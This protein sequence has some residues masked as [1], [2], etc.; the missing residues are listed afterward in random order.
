VTSDPVARYLSQ[1]SARHER[2]L[3]LRPMSSG[4]V[5]D[6]GLRVY[7]ALG[8]TFLRIT[9]VPALFCLAGFAFLVLY[10]LPGL[11]TTAQP[12]DIMVQIAEASVALAMA[13][14]I[15]GPLFLLGFSYS[16]AVITH[17][18]ADY[19]VGN[20]LDPAQAERQARGQLPKLFFVSMREL[21]LSVSGLGVA[22]ALM[23]G[24]ALLS[25]MTPETSALAGL[26]AFVGILGLFGGVLVFLYVASRHA[27]AAPAA[28]L[29]DLSGR[30]AA[31]RSKELFRAVPYHGSGTGAIWT[32][33]FL[34]FFVGLLLVGGMFLSAQMLGMFG[35]LEGISQ[36]LPFGDT[37]LTALS[38]LPWYVVIWTLLPV[39]AATVVLV[40][41][42]RRVRLEGYDIEALASEIGRH[43]RASRF[44]L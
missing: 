13:L 43:G 17:L 3:Q 22:I 24:G 27:L 9:A 32:L 20:P 33:Y 36:A 37:I 41:Y 1:R 12:M 23:M 19:V 42:E 15:G 26:V 34:L 2:K 8:W 7:Q 5:I 14:F 18:V 31:A 28:V 29:E 38:L 4:E 44:D 35:I 11:T 30:Q 40:Y 25:E 10:V 21:L 16:T 6:A 39:W